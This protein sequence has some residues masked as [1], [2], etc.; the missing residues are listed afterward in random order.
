MYDVKVPARVELCEHHGQP[1][2]RLGDAVFALILLPAGTTAARALDFTLP[3]QAEQVKVSQTVILWWHVMENTLHE[4]LLDY[5]P[6]KTSQGQNVA[7][8]RSVRYCPQ[9]GPTTRD[10]LSHC[11]SGIPAVLDFLAAEQRRL[12]GMLWH[13]PRRNSLGCTYPGLIYSE[14]GFS[15][16]L[17]PHPA[18]V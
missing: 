12:E 5:L 15:T 17:W 10:V 3:V 6:C 7:I 11:E 1:M 16:R 18:S 9:D 13:E 2:L 8:E 4:P 14:S